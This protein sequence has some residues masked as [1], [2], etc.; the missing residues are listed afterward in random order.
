MFE[1]AKK[2]PAASLI[3]DSAET[4]R[5]RRFLEWREKR[6]CSYRVSVE[7]LHDFFVQKQIKTG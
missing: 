3:V 2:S 4:N 6:V 5:M 1:I 7:K